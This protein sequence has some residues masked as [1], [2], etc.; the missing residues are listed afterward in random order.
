MTAPVLRGVCNVPPASRW[1][2][3]D[4]VNLI[5]GQSRRLFEICIALERWM[6]MCAVCTRESRT[7]R[8]REREKVK[9]SKEHYGK[10]YYKR[11]VRDQGRRRLDRL[12]GIKDNSMTRT[13]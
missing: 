12:N 4:N 8:K 3:L 7:Q 10:Y 13:E 11:L 9:V 5:Y 6:N 2:K 1:T